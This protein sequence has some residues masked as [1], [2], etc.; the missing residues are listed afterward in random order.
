MKLEILSDVAVSPNFES[1][2][3]S[4][5]CAYPLS[6]R[7]ADGSI[8]CVYRQGSSKHSPDGI[9]LS[10]SSR[11][12]KSWSDPQILFDGRHRDPAV[13][14]VSGGAGQTDTGALIVLFGSIEGL[15][16]GVYMFDDDGRSLPH[17]VLL[18]RSEDGGES[19]SETILETGQ[20]P[21]AGITSRPFPVP[22]GG[23]C[24]PLEH[25][26]R[27]GPLGTSV[28][29][30]GDDVRRF[31]E[32]YLCAADPEGEKNLCDARFSVLP[33]GRIL[34][35]LWTFLQSSERTIEVHRSF[36]SD[37][38]KTWQEPVSIGFVGQ[39][40]APL[41]LPSGEVIAASNYRHRPEG[42][43]LWHSHNGGVDWDTQSPIQMWDVASSR[44]LG[45]TVAA[46]ATPEGDENIWQALDQFTFGTPDL[47]LLDQ[48][49]VLLTYY[50]TFEEVHPRSGLSGPAPGN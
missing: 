12:G 29:I 45:Q 24:I 28:L 8:F 7:L 9:L 41:A 27:F 15:E 10:Q 11:D 6:N 33:D 47:V 49:V 37:G 46:G 4:S 23:F 18:L 14:V 17:P 32:P 36:S 42:I 1:R 5:A 19:W 50:A 21:R 43:R 39:I 2:Q 16:E 35:L 38:G 44:M 3:A 30:G 34:A 40:T 26:S 20:L 22:D 13:T 48:G 31:G 25:P